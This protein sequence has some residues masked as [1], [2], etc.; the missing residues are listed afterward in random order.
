MLTALCQYQGFKLLEDGMRRTAVVSA[1]ALLALLL[2]GY[3]RLGVYTFPP[4]GVAPDG[5][6][7]I[8]LRQGQEPFFNSPRAMCEVV[9]GG[10]SWQCAW[11]AVLNAP[12]D[13]ALVKLPYLDWAYRASLP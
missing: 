10:S 7:M 2:I 1:V 13:R 8:V 9:G 11:G 12:I 3:F 6:T 4:M 5:R